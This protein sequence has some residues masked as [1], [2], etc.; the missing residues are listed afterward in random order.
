[1]IR[2]L[3][4][5]DAAKYWDLRLQAL[6]INP[7]AFAT[8]YEEELKKENP[9]EQVTQNLQSHTSHTFGVFNESDTLLGVVTLLTE[10]KLAFKHKGHIVA[11]YVDAHSRGNGYARD[12]LQ[13]VIEKAKELHIE[14]LC[15]GVVSNNESAKG[16]YKSIGFTT[17]GIEKRALKTNGIYRDEQHMVLFL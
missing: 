7:E 12:L 6:Q 16:L 8:T 5:L 2:I 17:Y 1:M 14:Q 4:E 9:I 13:A 15:L 3:S 10:Q 11:M